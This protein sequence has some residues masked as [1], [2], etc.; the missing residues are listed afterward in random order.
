MIPLHC[1][2]PSLTACR[3]SER[4]T[5][6]NQAGSLVLMM[7]AGALVSVL[8]LTVPIRQDHRPATREEGGARHRHIHASHPAQR[9]SQTNK[10]CVTILG[11]MPG[12]DGTLLSL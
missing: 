6:D 8:H 5:A 3:W 9:G 4:K 11:A 1:R 2:A 10:G 12:A 7:Q